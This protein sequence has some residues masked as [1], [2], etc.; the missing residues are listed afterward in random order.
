[1]ST[2]VHSHPNFA[3]PAQH[4]GNRRRSAPQR[5]DRKRVLALGAVI[6]MH[7]LLL[8][9]LYLPQ[10][11]S[12][13]VVA[14]TNVDL[15]FEFRDPEPPPP[16]PPPPQQRRE[17]P[18]LRTE[19]PPAPA[20]A[21]ARVIE[22]TAPAFVDPEPSEVAATPTPQPVAP[23]RPATGSA[24][25]V[26]VA[27]RYLKAPPPQYPIQL[28]RRNVEGSVTLRVLVDA[29]GNPKRVEVLQGSGQSALDQA[30]LRVVRS[31]WRFQPAMRDGRAVAVW[32][33]VDI[34]FRLQD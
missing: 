2:P 17:T 1:M 32:G 27:L 11:A 14:R 34:R 16:A 22:I 10:Q 7:L 28:L 33:R 15:D 21:T 5:S 19:A 26:Y 30:A 24:E 18:V 20:L 9:L 29:Q 25:A 6:S 31:R 23:A 8:G 4:P 13:P 12:V 3:F